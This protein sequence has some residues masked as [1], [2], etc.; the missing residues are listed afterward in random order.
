MTQYIVEVSHTDS[1]CIQGLN[2]IVE[3]GMHLLHHTWF[4]CAAGDHT[5]WLQLEA[6]TE[7]EARNV[8][9]PSMRSKARVVEVQKFTPAQI[10]DLHPRR[11]QPANVA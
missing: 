5:G 3:W 1:E 2:T 11:A 4:G 10:R 8:L 6:D 7:A 9:P